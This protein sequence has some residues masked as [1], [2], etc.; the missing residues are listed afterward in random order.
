MSYM[1]IA[2]FTHVVILIISSDFR[3]PV[4]RK[5]VSLFKEILSTV[6]SKLNSKPLTVEGFELASVSTC[7]YIS[8]MIFKDDG[9][10]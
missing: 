10:L 2:C 1:R 5:V 8:H 7:M 6:H 4:Q 9:N 3:D